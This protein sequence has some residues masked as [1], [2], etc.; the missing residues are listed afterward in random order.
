MNHDVKSIVTEYLESHGFDGLY[1]SDGEC[2]C[3][4]YGGLF[5]CEFTDEYC[6]AGY[7]QQ[8]NGANGEYDF[9]IGKDKPIPVLPDIAANADI[10]GAET[11]GG[12]GLI[13]TTSGL[14]VVC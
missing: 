13:D 5:Q 10:S 8:S 11:A 12:R 9:V 2:A 14:F 1:N 7:Y 3:D 4:L 6:N